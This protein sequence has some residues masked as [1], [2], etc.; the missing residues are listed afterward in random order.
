MKKIDLPH[1]SWAYEEFIDEDE[2]QKLVEWMKSVEHLA[3]LN[4][5]GRKFIQHANRL[6]NIPSVYHEVKN[7]IIKLEGLEKAN[8][9][10]QTFGDFLSYNSNEGKIQPHTDPGAPNFDHIRYNLLVQVP[11]EGGDAIYG[12][13][14]VHIK[15]KMIWRCEASTHIHS[16]TPVKGERERLNISFGFLVPFA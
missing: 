3:I 15:E 10:T 6:T 9:G 13:E 11:T 14:I 5:I 16:S 7:R 4:G 2:R 8:Q 1:G 12:N